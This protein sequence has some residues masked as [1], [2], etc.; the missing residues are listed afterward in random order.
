MLY[1]LLLGYHKLQ[2]LAGATLLIGLWIDQSDS[3][4]H[5]EEL[6]LLLL[7]LMAKIDLHLE[8]VLYSACVMVE[9][10]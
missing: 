6:T 4:E 2:L 3:R 7:P 1:S 5:I 8:V 9:L 10:D